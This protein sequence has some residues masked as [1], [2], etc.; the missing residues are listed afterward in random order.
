MFTVQ[1]GS[2]RPCEMLWYVVL[3]LGLCLLLPAVVN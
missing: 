3:T 1:K 2:V